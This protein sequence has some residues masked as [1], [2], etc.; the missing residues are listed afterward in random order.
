[1][2]ATTP[3]TIPA[4]A[5]VE[6]P[7]CYEVESFESGGGLEL[8]V[9]VVSDDDVENGRED[10]AVEGADES[11]ASVREL[12]RLKDADLEA[13]DGLNELSST[14]RLPHSEFRA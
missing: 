12:A 1:M 2:P 7:F 3:I 9:L 4:I 6:R 11:E 13:D 8:K 5:P 10:D 14:V